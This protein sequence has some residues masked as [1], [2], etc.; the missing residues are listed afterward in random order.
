M[1]DAEAMLVHEVIGVAGRKREPDVPHDSQADNLWRRAGR[2]ERGS[3]G[4]RGTLGSM[5]S[6]LEG[7]SVTVPAGEV[8]RVP[9]ATLSLRLTLTGAV[10]FVF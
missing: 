10:F 4:P 9:F 8:E 6:L 7:S 3:L 2:A 5:V 1:T